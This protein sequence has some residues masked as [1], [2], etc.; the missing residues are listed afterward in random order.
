[1]ETIQEKAETTGIIVGRFH[2]DELT[3][4]QQNLFDRVSKAH[5]KVIVFLGLS[6][7]KCTFNNPLD[8][9]SRKIMVKEMYPKVDVYYIN[10]VGDDIIW[11]DTLDKQISMRLK[12]DE[13]VRL[14]GSRDSFIQYYSGNFPTTVLEPE[15][16]TSGTARRKELASKVNKT[17]DYRQGVINAVFNQWP[18]ALPTVD[19]AVFNENKTR[20]LM[21]RKPGETKY[22]FAGGFVEP[23][24]TLEDTVDKETGEEMHLT[25][26]EKVYVKSFHID[27]W[28]YRSEQ[29]KITTSLFEITAWEGTPEPDD[30]IEELRWFPFNKYTVDSI[31]TEHREMFTYLL[32]K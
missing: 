22:R 12:N 1:M 16:F 4:G 20:I 3:E 32:E 7:C 23:G 19:M 10:D 25:V 21:A 29:N 18:A 24:M 2:V 26:L 17:K 28:R 5:E 30:D 15:V 8:F 9:E 14:Y 13:T 31:I 27:D 6:P 11:S